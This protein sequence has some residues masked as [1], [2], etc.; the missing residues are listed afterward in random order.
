MSKYIGLF[1]ACFS[2]IFI[3]DHVATID[4]CTVRV[5]LLQSLI[6]DGFIKNDLKYFNKWIKDFKEKE[7]LEDE[8][9]EQDKI[10]A[11]LKRGVT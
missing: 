5:D 8:E 9:F 7:S 11:L 10:K 6:N 1:V 4:V 2:I 3:I